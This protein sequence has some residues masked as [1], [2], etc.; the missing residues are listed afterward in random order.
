SR[1]AELVCKRPRSGLDIL[2]CAG[3]SRVPNAAD[4]LG[5]P[6]ME[7]LLRIAS[8]SYDYIV[9]EIAPIMSVVDL[10]MIGGFIDGFIFV[11][12]WGQTKRV[13][14]LE[15]LS[16]VD[17]LRERLIGVVLNK[18]DPAALRTIEAYKGRRVGDYY[19]E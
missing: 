6:K 11:V 4:L 13:L 15:A 10:K 3:A 16:E 9:V 8:N 12:E 19:Q 17:A 1:L 5:S 7:K 2:P 18:A 14:V